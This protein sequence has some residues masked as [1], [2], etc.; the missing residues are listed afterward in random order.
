MNREGR[1][2]LLGVGWGFISSGLLSG[3][4][5]GPFISS[6]SLGLWCSMW[7]PQPSPSIW[8]WRVDG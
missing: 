7:H 3:P 4:I 1:L 5:F 6:G 2:C 8:I